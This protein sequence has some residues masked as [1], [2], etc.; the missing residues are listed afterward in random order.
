MENIGSSNSQDSE[1]EFNFKKSNIARDIYLTPSGEH[2][3]TVIWLHGLGDS[4]EGF[5][6]FF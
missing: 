3:F 1:F 5:L 6:D 2:K 4:A